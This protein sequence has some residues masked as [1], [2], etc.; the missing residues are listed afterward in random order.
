MVDTGDLS[1]PQP[2]PI[3]AEINA[4]RRNYVLTGLAVDGSP[5]GYMHLE[6]KD[7][8]DQTAGCPRWMKK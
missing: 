4:F 7:H 2:F 5:N 3:P 8:V 1:E 6:R